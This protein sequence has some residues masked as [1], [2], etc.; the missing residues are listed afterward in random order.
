MDA[1]STTL[2]TWFRCCVVIGTHMG[3][4][5]PI[6]TLNLEPRRELSMASQLP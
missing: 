6:K 5:R 4:I 3:I 1:T 2:L